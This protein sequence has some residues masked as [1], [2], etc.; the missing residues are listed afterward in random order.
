MACLVRHGRDD[1]RDGKN[2]GQDMVC[3]TI[4]IYDKRLSSTLTS[5]LDVSLARHIGY[6][7]T[8]ANEDFLVKTPSTLGLPILVGVPKCWGFSRESLH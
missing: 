4:Y 1:F 5:I 8:R 6:P 2:E 7:N 3:P